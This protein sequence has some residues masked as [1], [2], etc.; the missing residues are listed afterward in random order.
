MSTTTLQRTDAPSSA[1]DLSFPNADI[2]HSDAPASVALAD[3]WDAN[4]SGWKAWRRHLATPG[5][6]SLSELI[7]S[8]CPL[9]WGASTL[10]VDQDSL[11]LVELLSRAARG[12]RSAGQTAGEQLEMWLRES[13]G[14]MH[15]EP[16][17]LECVAWAQ[18]LP[19]LARF[20]P[21]DQWWDLLVRLLGAAQA[22]VASHQYET[23]LAW[24]LLQVEL[25]LTLAWLLP[26][27]SACQSL[28]ASG[29]RSLA[30]DLS[31]GA[32]ES[33]LLAPRNAPLLRARLASWLRSLAIANELPPSGQDEA[34]PSL[35]AVVLHALRFTCPSG[36]QAFERRPIADRPVDLFR[37]A[38][39]RV[40]DPQLRDVAA[41]LFPAFRSKRAK[42][43]TAAPPP[44]AWHSEDAALGVLRRDWSAD[45]EMLAVRYND[46]RVHSDLAC[47]RE[48]LWSG[49]W[50]VDLRFDGKTLEQRS[51]WD[52]VCWVSDDGVDYLEIEARFTGGVRVQRQMLLTRK[53]RLLYLADAV[54]GQTEAPIEYRGLLP[55]APNIEAQPAEETRE[56]SL[57]GRRHCR[58]QPLALPEW[59]RDPRGGSLAPAAEGLEL[60]QNR[61]GRRLYAPLLIDLDPRR[62]RQP[63][64]WRQLTIAEDRRTVTADVAV[65]YRVQIG[66]QQWL[67][68]RALGERANRTLLGSNL[69]SE[70]MFARFTSEGE[71]E[72]L[73]EIE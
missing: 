56:V 34:P 47:G 73:L 64:T 57:V 19:A 10:S 62:A 38:L 35:D 72:P 33:H 46:R 26:E 6:P 5:R 36:R 67:I 40:D 51:D 39:K 11:D 68:Y 31:A 16:T 52:H 15:L 53:D 29:R 18:A 48:T 24:H 23:P 32:D 14:G 20:A 37:E 27:I 42:R 4:T 22:S 28:G 41:S 61:H 54:L 65:G 21:A 71:V 59:R 13:A 7:A 25:P 55:L 45:G 60:C 63:L 3:A 9:W 70:F 44:S 69:V 49:I 58:V 50:H 2:W 12:S 66:K 8:R 17:A 43:R 1:S 30:E